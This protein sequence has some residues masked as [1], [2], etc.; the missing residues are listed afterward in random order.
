MTLAWEI[1]V[2]FLLLLFHMRVCI[3][4]FVNVVVLY[5]IRSGQSQNGITIRAT[6]TSHIRTV[7]N[8]NHV[9]SE[10]TTCGYVTYFTQI[11][12]FNLGCV[13]FGSLCSGGSRSARSPRP[14]Y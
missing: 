2:P 10:A 8:Y 6:G 13:L 14:G 12:P 9:W 3:S 1:N 7:P 11:I 4:T 5:R